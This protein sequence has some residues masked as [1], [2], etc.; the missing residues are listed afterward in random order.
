[1]DVDKC[2]YDGLTMSGLLRKLWIHHR[3]I[4]R[5][6]ILLGER[7]KE[8]KEEGRGGRQGKGEEGEDRTER[9]KILKHKTTS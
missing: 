5:T 9:E 2:I 1:M 8:G 7:E 3:E 6:G 4:V